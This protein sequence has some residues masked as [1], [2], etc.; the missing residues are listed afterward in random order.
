MQKLWRLAV[1]DHLHV[2]GLNNKFAESDATVIESAREP[3]A[4]VA[5]LRLAA[6]AFRRG[7]DPSDFAQKHPALAKALKRD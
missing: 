1:V 4:G 7:I 2:N 6:E 3:G 5:A